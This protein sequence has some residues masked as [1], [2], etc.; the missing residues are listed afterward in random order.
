[1]N[2]LSASNVGDKLLQRCRG[3]KPE[4]LSELCPEYVAV[5]T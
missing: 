4:V 2:S 5:I 3:Q 1:M